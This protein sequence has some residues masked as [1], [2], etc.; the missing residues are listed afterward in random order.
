MLLVISIFLLQGCATNK[1]P[2]PLPALFINGDAL[3]DAPELARRGEYKV[4]V[5]TLN[6]INKAQI[7]ILK[8]KDGIDPLYDRQLKVEV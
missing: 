4:G 7:N 8:S 3:P 1:N 5:R 2:S 6:F